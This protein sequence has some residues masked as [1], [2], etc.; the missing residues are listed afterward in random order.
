MVARLY[1]AFDRQLSELERRFF[2]P[3]ESVGDDERAPARRNGGDE[4]AAAGERDARI[5]ATLA[6]TLEQLIALDGDEGGA[7]ESDD[8]GALDELRAALAERLGRLGEG[9]E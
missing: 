9:G 5:L 7:K 6:K 3:A 2:S 1:G 8:G 4:G